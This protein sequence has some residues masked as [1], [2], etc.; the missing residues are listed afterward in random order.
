MKDNDGAIIAVCG[1]GGV[2][3]TAFCALLARV[4][5][6]SGRSPLLLVD[7]D[8]AGGLVS[9]IGEVVDGSLAGVRDRLIEAAKSGDDAEK[10]RLAEQIDYLVME[11][12]VERPGY[13]FLAMG[14]SR[15]AG[16]FCPANILVREAIDLIS[17]PFSAVLIDAEAGIEQINRRVTRRVG[18]IVALTDGSSRG[19]ETL[20]TIAGMA[21][22]GRVSAVVNRGGGAHVAGLPDGV[23]LLGTIP[24]DPA[25]LQ[26]DRQGRSLWE[27]PAENRALAAV[28]AIARKLEF[29]NTAGMS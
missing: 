26:F 24:E 25:L 28:R 4:L 1:K 14:H 17:E 8:P 29:V 20:K 23:V 12:L 27:L 21:G 11:A 22:P 5:L 13:S 16:C 10:M 6:E 7:A 9:A 15:Q 2:G 19:A 3:K 18:R